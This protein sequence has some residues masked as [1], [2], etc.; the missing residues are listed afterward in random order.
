MIDKVQH[1]LPSGYTNSVNNIDGKLGA[2][3]NGKVQQ[4]SNSTEV[5]LS[6]DA[7]ALQRIMQAAKDAPDVRTDLVQKIKGQIQAGTYQ[8]NTENVAAKLLPFMQ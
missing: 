2:V 3:Q 6:G 8:V 1:S 7:L 4:V 5:S